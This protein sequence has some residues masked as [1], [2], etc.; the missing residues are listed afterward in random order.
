MFRDI[1]LD[2]NSSDRDI[3]RFSQANNIILLTSN[4]NM[5]GEDSIII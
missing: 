2:N 5:E 1:G 4:R 3:W